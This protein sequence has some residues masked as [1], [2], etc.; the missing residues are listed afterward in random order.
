[1]VQQWWC[2]LQLGL[3][4]YLDLPASVVYDK[5]E[6]KR[7][8][9]KEKLWDDFTCFTPRSWSNS[10]GDGRRASLMGSAASSPHLPAKQQQQHPK[11]LPRRRP[12]FWQRMQESLK[13]TLGGASASSTSKPS[14]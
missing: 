7:Q 8:L 12:S 13:Q 2:S 4:K 1:M 10:P 9:Y 14:K 11:T 3:S 5:F 6:E